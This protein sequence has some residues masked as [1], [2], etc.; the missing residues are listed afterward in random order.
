[1][2]TARFTLNCLYALAG[3]TIVEAFL[4][5]LPFTAIELLVSVLLLLFTAKI[6]NSLFALFTQATPIAESPYITALIL[7]FALA[8][9]QSALNALYLMIFATLAMLSKYILN[10]NKVHFLNPALV[11]LC[12]AGI[13]E[14]RFVVWWVGTPLVTIAVVVLGFM[15]VRKLNAFKM[16]GI[17]LSVS[18]IAFVVTLFLKNSYSFYGFAG[19]LLPFFASTPVFFFA[20]F[21]LTDPQTTPRKIHHQNIYAA[22][23]GAVFQLSFIT[24]SIAGLLGNLYTSLSERNSRYVL[25]FRVATKISNIVWEYSFAPKKKIS[26]LPGQYLEFSLPHKSN[27]SRGNRRIFWISSSPTDPLIRFV[28]TIPNESSTFKDALLSL[29]NGTTVTATG[30]SGNVF[31][32]SNPL[33]KICVVVEG[34][35]IAPLMSVFRCLSDRHERRDIVLIYSART[36]LEFLYQEE[37][38]VIKDS[39]GVRVIYVPLDFPELSNWKGLT[40]RITPEF[41]KKHVPDIAR[42]EQFTVSSSGKVIHN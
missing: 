4:G 12:I 34:V 7:F 28:T 6:S 25:S 33:S 19:V 10:H 29:K 11:A 2:T 40:G 42:R 30:P 17:F 3:V 23:V 21:V 14:P 24:P 15:V 36:P 38:D 39:I 20:A 31:L 5:W 35:G 8:P 26:F 13:I 22:M 27:D 32:P 16:S 37:I 1:M 41:I 18:F 9:I